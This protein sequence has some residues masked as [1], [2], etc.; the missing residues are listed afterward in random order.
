M[1]ICN[2]VAVAF[3]LSPDVPSTQALC[4]L[5]NKNAPVS[6]AETGASAFFSFAANSTYSVESRWQP[7]SFDVAFTTTTHR[8]RAADCASGFSFFLNKNFVNHL[9]VYQLMNWSN[10]ELRPKIPA[11][12]PVVKH[13]CSYFFHPG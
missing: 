10:H 12:T 7:V 6:A 1:E 9:S 5:K 2:L 13:V 4:L 3:I 8:H 11:A